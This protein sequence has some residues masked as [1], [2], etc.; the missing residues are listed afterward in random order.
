[1]VTSDGGFARFVR[2][3]VVPQVLP[4][5]FSVA[6]MRR[7]MFRTI[8]QTA[9]QYRDCTLSSGSAGAVQSGDRLPWIRLGEDSAAADNFAPLRSLDWQVHV[10]G[11][12]KPAVEE[13]CQAHALALHAYPWRDTM[14]AAG[15]ARNATYL[16]RPDGYVGFAD[17]GANAEALQQYVAKWVLAA[18]P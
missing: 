2:T 6:A 1:L 8:S 14:R 18:R 5:I 7:F 10:Y 3:R 11:E 17:S 4:R 16:I 9:I 15:I 12:A 13:L